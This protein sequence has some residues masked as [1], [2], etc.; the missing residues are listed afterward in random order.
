MKSRR[1]HGYV[2]DVSSV[3]KSVRAV[4]ETNT[5]HSIDSHQNVVHLTYILEKLLKLLDDRIVLEDPF[6]V[7]QVWSIDDSDVDLSG[8]P[9]FIRDIISGYL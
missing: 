3:D 1:I 8:F 2:I 6:F 5:W 4:C 9:P 7:S